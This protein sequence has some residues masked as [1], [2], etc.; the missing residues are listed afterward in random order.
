MNPK[1]WGNAEQVF[2]QFGLTKGSLYKLADTGQIDSA[3]I[4]TREGS[5]KSIRLFS[6]SSIRKLLADNLS[7]QSKKHEAQT[8]PSSKTDR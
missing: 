6:F 4:K 8:L 7:A 3:S 2:E 5:R 1:E